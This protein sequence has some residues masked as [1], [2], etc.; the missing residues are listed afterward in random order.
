MS[1]KAPSRLLVAAVLGGAAAL[2]WSSAADEGRV[3]ADLG[4]A[5]FFPIS[6]FALDGVQD[7][8]LSAIVAA[9][10]VPE[11]T[12]VLGFD[13]EAARA[14]VEALPWVEEAQIRAALSGE[15]S[16]AIR[17]A[18][19]VA[20]WFDGIAER[21]IASD[22]SV[23]DDAV[24]RQ[25]R[26]LP[27]V[28]GKGAEVG[29]DEARE[30]VATQPFIE[31]HVAAVVRVGQRRWDLRLVNGTTVRL[32]EADP[33]FALDRLSSIPGVTELFTGS[34][35]VIDLRLPGRTSI[36]FGAA[37]LHPDAPLETLPAAEDPL[38]A[39]ILEAMPSDPLAA[40]IRA[41]QA[42]GFGASSNG[43]AL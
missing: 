25:F 7:G 4:R 5:G 39:A 24:D 14:N 26:H 21:L 38:A 34:P 20:R 8:S 22:G 18:Q 17:E 29:V 23:L 41:A 32:P 13:V 12:S 6:H 37:P 15:V 16:F 33:S 40:A 27:L 31:P 35:L 36:A 2:G 9:I 19:P 28:A 42:G 43:G 3:W 10:D 30:L 1:T 11:H